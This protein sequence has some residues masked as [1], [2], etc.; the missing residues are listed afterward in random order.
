MRDQPE[1]QRPASGLRRL[2]SSRLLNP[3]RRLIARR[4]DRWL[5]SSRVAAREFAGMIPPRYMWIGPR[6]S[7][8]H[9]FRWPHEYRVYLT[10]LCGLRPD[11]SVLELGCGHGRTALG[12]V[13]YL[14]P[15]GRYEGL[16]IDS[17]RIEFARRRIS[18]R[19]PQFRFSHAD[20]RNSLYNPLGTLAAEDF[21][22]PY[23]DA[24]FDV[25]Y[26]A[27]LFTHL[28]RDAT[29]AYLRESARVLRPRGRA[30]LSFFLLDFYRGRGTTTDDFY[31]FEHPQEGG[32]AVYDPGSPDTLV[33]HGRAELERLAEESGL[34]A[35]RL[36]PG[37]WSQPAGASF[38]EQD[39]LLFERR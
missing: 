18:A 26:A 7:I 30:L 27:S 39:L 4:E 12:L 9:F 36:L 23:E 1:L 38:N 5:N 10:L 29:A 11:G 14:S 33:A 25:V 3:V 19:Q 35:D 24:C 31:E 22:F 32:V 21:R 2:R 8:A 37:Y 15:Q 20:I 17:R 28:G 34:R 6:D 13:G 16:D